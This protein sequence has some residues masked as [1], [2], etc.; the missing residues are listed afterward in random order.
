MILKVSGLLYGLALLNSVGVD[1]APYAPPAMQV[2]NGA[3]LQTISDAWIRRIVKDARHQALLAYPVAEQ[4]VLSGRTELRAS[5]SP[6]ISPEYASLPVE[7]RVDGTLVRTVYVGYRIVTLVTMPVLTHAKHRG[8][9]LS[10]NDFH[11]EMRAADGRSPVDVSMLSGHICNA[12]LAAGSVVRP[13]QTSVD[14][15]VKA[16]SP[17]VLIVHDGGVAL[18]ADVIARTSGGFGEVVTVYD[19]PSRKVLSG[20]VTAPSRVELT[21]PEVSEE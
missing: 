5:A 14:Q 12:D 1:A 20:L 6:V 21:L 11:D 4:R 3:R 17:V 15:I 7:I 10:A 9:M 18:A 13:E 19:E 16:G 2:V 8:D